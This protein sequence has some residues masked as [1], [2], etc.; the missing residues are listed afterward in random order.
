MKD[1]YSG[2][3]RLFLLDTGCFGISSFYNKKL[4]S[5]NIVSGISIHIIVILVFQYER[6]IQDQNSYLPQ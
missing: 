2:F 6:P 5:N 1:K 3:P 4:K